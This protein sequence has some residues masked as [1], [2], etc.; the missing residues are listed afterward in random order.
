MADDRVLSR[1]D[2]LRRRLRQTSG[3]GRKVRGLLALLLPYRLRVSA[4]LV[5]LLVSTAAALAPAPL[6]KLA[7][8]DGIRAGD[9]HTLDLVVV[10]FLVSAVLVWV[11]SY[12]QSYLT[13]WVGQRALQDLRRQ[14][15]AHL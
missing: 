8:D 11:G 4:M 10:A 12:A 15:F 2:D 14:I 7:I 3:R 6:A 9:R 13:G 5:A 1:R